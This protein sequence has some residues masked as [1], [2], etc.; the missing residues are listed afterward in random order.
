[1]TT[2]VI[3]DDDRLVCEHLQ[4]RLRRGEDLECVGVAHAADGARELVARERPD[5]V[6]L[7]IMLPDVPDPIELAAEL[8]RLSP[9]SRIAI[10]TAWS[11]S[12]LLDRER[13]FRLKVR[14]SRSGIVAWISKGRGVHEVI[15]ELSETARW[16]ARQVGPSPLERALGEYLQTVGSAFGADPFSGSGDGETRLTPMEA[17]IAAIVAHGLEANLNIDQIAKNTGIVAGTIRGHIKSIYAK[18]GV[19]NQ[20]AFVAEARRRGLLGADRD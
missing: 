1:V 14:A 7:D 18:R 9:R 6:V 12:I 5:L 4:E 3:I 13:E 8:T 10:C 15:A 2:V 20:A 19:S 16:C 17:R 11:D